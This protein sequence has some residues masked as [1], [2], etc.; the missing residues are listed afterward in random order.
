MYC[1]SSAN[2]LRNSLKNFYISVVTAT[3]CTISEPLMVSPFTS[4]AS[5]SFRGVCELT[6]LTSCNGTE[7]GFAVRV[8]FLSDS[9]AN[10]AVGVLMGQDQRWISREDGSFFSDV[11]PAPS[12]NPGVLEF[13]GSDITVTLNPAQSTTEIVVGG[14]IQVTVVHKYGGVL[15]GSEN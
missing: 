4:A 2:Q 14:G 15:L 5:F 1:N 7:P 9:E 3:E 10:G 13:P 8:D 11:P 12:G 6:A